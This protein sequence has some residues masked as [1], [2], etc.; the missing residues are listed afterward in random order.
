[1]LHS[2]LVF[3][4]F[5]LGLSMFRFGWKHDGFWPRLALSVGAVLVVMAA[6]RIN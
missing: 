1:M 5:N 4:L 6:K 3:G 2:F